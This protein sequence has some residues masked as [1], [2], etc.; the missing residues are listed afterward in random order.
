MKNVMLDR[1]G[2]RGEIIKD[3]MLRERR[4]KKKSEDEMQSAHILFLRNENNLINEQSKRNPPKTQ[5]REQPT[6]VYIIKAIGTSFYKI[7]ISINPQKRLYALQT[8]NPNKLM[9]VKKYKFQSKLEA[10]AVEKEMHRHLKKHICLGGTEWF[11]NEKNIIDQTK[12]LIEERLS[13]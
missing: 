7:G 10:T 13:V 4:N 11:R 6:F 8:A 1:V 12:N 9:I 5:K 3:I 2:I